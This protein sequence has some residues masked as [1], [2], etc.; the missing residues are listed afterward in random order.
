MVDLWNR[1]RHLPEDHLLRV[2]MSESLALGGDVSVSWLSDFCA[3]LSVCGGL[4][5]SGLAYRA[6]RGVPVGR[7][8]AAYGA[9]VDG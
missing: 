1:L 6:W 2:T 7:Y 5:E 4:P 3:F 8:G 9:C